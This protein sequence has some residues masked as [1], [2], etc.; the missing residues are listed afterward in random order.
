MT[1]ELELFH[2][3]SKE[4]NYDHF[5][6][7]SSKVDRLHTGRKKQTLVN[8]SGCIVPKWASEG[9]GDGEIK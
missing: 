6:D 3:G 2:S 8:I 5:C 7:F 1:S 9:H 4:Q